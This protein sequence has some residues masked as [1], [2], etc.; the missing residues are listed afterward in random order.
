M[1]NCA[2]FLRER[3]NLTYL[4]E[5]VCVSRFRPR[6]TAACGEEKHEGGGGEAREGG[7]RGKDGGGPG[8]GGRGRGNRKPRADQEV[9]AIIG[10]IILSLGNLSVQKIHTHTHTHTHTPT[11]TRQ[12]RQHSLREGGG[13]QSRMNFPGG[14]PPWPVFPWERRKRIDHF[15]SACAYRLRATA[16]GHLFGVCGPAVLLKKDFLTGRSRYKNNLVN[17]HQHNLSRTNSLLQFNLAFIILK[18][19]KQTQVSSSAVP[20]SA[21]PSSAVPSSAVPSSAVRADYICIYIHGTFSTWA[22]ARISFLI[23]HSRNCLEKLENKSGKTYFRRDLKPPRG[24]DPKFVTR[25]GFVGRATKVG[26]SCKDES[27]TWTNAYTS[28]WGIVR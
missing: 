22:D 11:H 28:I 24:K 12:G 10:K 6:H 3:R 13:E 9:A 7:G 19:E 18:K 15:E 17:A 25:H 14:R 2:F 4:E 21:V 20:N 27:K 5:T 8:G 1:R 23:S 26:K 16:A